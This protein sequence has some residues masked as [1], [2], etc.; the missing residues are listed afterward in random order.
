MTDVREGTIDVDRV[1]DEGRWGRYQRWLVWLTA[2]AIVFDGFD[3]QLLGIALP[4]IIQ[5]W[6]VARS[7]FAPVVSVGYLGMMIGG[8]V[9]GL[10]GDRFGRRVALLGS[11]MIFGAATLAVSGVGGLTGLA[12]LRLISGLGLG[13]AI[14]NAT[15]LAAEYVPGRQRPL[16]V[17]LAIV[18]VPIGGTVAGL[19]AVPG[20]PA[21][22]W[23][24]MFMLGGFIPMVLALVLWR[25]LPESP[26]YLARHQRRWP[27]LARLL[28]RMGHA[29]PD[30]AAFADLT[31][32]AKSSA[33]FKALFADNLRGDTFALWTAYFS[34]LLAVYLAF[35]WLPSILSAAG[36]GAAVA[37]TGL[38][39]FNLGG[40]VG[41]IAGGAIIGRTG[42][43]AAM[44]AMTTGAVVGAVALSQ[45]AITAQSSVMPIIVM[46]AITGGFINAV[47]VALYA[48]SAHVYTT[49]VRATGI[50][51]A[52]A[53]GRSGSILSGYAG[54]WALAYGG[55]AS[56][57]HLMAISMLIT[58]V[59][60]AVT[61]RHIPTRSQVSQ[62]A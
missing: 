43:R 21:F 36:L 23:R 10:A 30:E 35:S 20:L 4:A 39:V 2:L 44:L 3:N 1:L 53:V 24:G 16:A 25:L 59:A 31:E 49:T 7:A 62:G 32:G 37:S 60:L 15:A 61:R 54:P 38:T 18:C 12:I 19:T 13:G 47:Q 11:L 34:S 40:V 17:S 22:G 58:F 51:T 27:E 46:L 48:L 50:G 33:P 5:D 57:F 45:M 14:P 28:R 26:R 6:R 29:V 56:F 55:S 52:V 9:A 41:A 8:A 42:S